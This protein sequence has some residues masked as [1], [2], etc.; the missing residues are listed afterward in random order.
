MSVKRWFVTVDWCSRGKRGVFCSAKGNAF[1]KETQHTEEEM[2]GILKGFY[3]VLDPKSIEL[4]K[5]ELE[6]YNL[7]TPLAEFS[8]EYGYALKGSKR[9]TN[10]GS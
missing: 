6:E 9:E 5:K 7:F 3:L 1:S 8:N 2:W 10:Q 4:S